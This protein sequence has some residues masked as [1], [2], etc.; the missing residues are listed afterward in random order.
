MKY[1][2]NLRDGNGDFLR[3][4]EAAGDFELSD[5]GVNVYLAPREEM[6]EPFITIGGDEGMPFCSYSN[7]EDAYMRGGIRILEPEI[8]PAAAI[9]GKI[10]GLVWEQPF[11]VTVPL[12]LADRQKGY[13]ED[14]EEVTGREIRI[15]GYS[16]G[17]GVILKA[18]R[19]LHSYLLSVVRGLP[20]L[21]VT[22]ASSM[23][24]QLS[25]L[26]RT[27]E[28]AVYL[29]V[30]NAICARESYSRPWERLSLTGRLIQK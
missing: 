28:E 17:P 15:M 14:L 29:E 19:E 18:P 12:G 30:L 16:E 27:R 7:F 22:H 24:N 5:E 9:I 10:S 25:I 21:E 20:H 13:R 11:Y 8:L 3:L 6:E 23:G 4:L 26:Y 2:V 1:L